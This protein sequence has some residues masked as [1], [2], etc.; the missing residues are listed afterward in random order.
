ME[1]TSKFRTSPKKEPSRV[2]S[3]KVSLKRAV[4]ITKTVKSNYNYYNENKIVCSKVGNLQDRM[5]QANFEFTKTTVN[6]S[7]HATKLSNCISARWTSDRSLYFSHAIQSIE[8]TKNSVLSFNSF[9]DEMDLLRSLVDKISERKN[10]LKQQ[11]NQI[12]IELDKLKF[13]HQAVE[14]RKELFV[15]AIDQSAQGK[16]IIAS[17]IDF[18]RAEIKSFLFK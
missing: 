12:E 1:R 5:E 16:D 2:K 4:G 15:K 7:E 9:G 3:F 10:K 14:T 17:E 6:L 13:E 18:L 11:K 8:Q